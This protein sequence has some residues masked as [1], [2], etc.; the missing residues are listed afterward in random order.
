[1]QS[2]RFDLQ[3]LSATILAGLPIE[4]AAVLAWPLACGSAVAER[5]QALGFYAG[6]L[7]VRVPDAGWRSQLERFSVTYTERLSKLLGTEISRIEF[8]IANR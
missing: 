7:Q 4:E 6:T 3:K 5:A 1:M 8:Q 2:A